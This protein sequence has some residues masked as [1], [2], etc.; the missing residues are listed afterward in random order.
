MMNELETKPYH[1][2]VDDVKQD[3]DKLRHNSH[4]RIFL[5]AKD[6]GVS[7]SKR[8]VGKTKNIRMHLDK[9]F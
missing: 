1:G 2:Q 3:D 9:K 8:Y 7:S 5:A 4:V 6:F